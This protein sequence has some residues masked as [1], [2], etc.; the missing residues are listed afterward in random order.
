MRLVTAALVLLLAAPAGARI[1]VRIEPRVPAD[2]PFLVH[3]HTWHG[4]IHSSDV[5]LRETRLV[6]GGWTNLRTGFPVPLLYYQSTIDLYHP[7]YVPQH[8]W[9]K[10]WVP[11][12]RPTALR[13][14][15]QS[16][17]DVLA[18]DGT[19]PHHSHGRNRFAKATFS[20]A[21]GTLAGYGAGYLPALDRAGIDVD[22]PAVLAWFTRLMDETWERR[23]SGPVDPERRRV[24]PGAAAEE[25]TELAALLEVSR[26]RRLLLWEFRERARRVYR[27]WDELFQPADAERLVVLLSEASAQERKRGE[28][29]WTNADSGLRWTYAWR[30][31]VEQRQGEARQP[32]LVGRMDADASPLV[33]FPVRDAGAG[34]EM[35]WCRSPDGTWHPAVRN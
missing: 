26:K 28:V 23:E 32:C 17:E 1:G 7:R 27:H 35:R 11:L 21:Y 25:L 31:R 18:S 29:R 34:R 12:F 19:V 33:G 10:G 16:W 13:L 15:P 8:E 5:D 4:R 20:A 14:E 30:R 2:E 22:G 9:V 24:S 6:R 3:L